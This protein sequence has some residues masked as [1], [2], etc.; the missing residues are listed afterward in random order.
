MGKIYT[1][2][3]WTD[4]LLS[5]SALYNILTNLGATI[6]NNV[7]IAL[8]T[9]VTTPGTSLTAAVMNNI[10]NGIDALDNKLVIDEAVLTALSGQ[11]QNITNNRI[12][13]SVASNNLTVALKGVD[14]NNPS[15]TN[16]VTVRIGNTIRTVTSALSVTL[17]AGTNWFGSGAAELAT[18]EIDYFVYLGY[19]VIDGVTIGV[20]RVPA[21]GLYGDFSATSTNAL[22]AAIS[23][24]THAAAGDEYT[25]IGRFAATLS[26]SAAYQWSV[27]TFT[28]DNLINRPIYETRWLLWQPTYSASGSMTWTSVLTYTASYQIRGDTLY[29]AVS[30]IG[31]T[32]GTADKQL[33]LTV[34]MALLSNSGVAAGTVLQDGAGSYISGVLI[35]ATPLLCFRRYDAANFGLGAVRT[36]N[37][38]SFY[39]V[40]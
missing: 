5:G 38:S 4:E 31:T 27:P 15:S 2:N 6:Y 3:T 8:A 21:A 26:A 34:P 14:G 37:L 40:M 16:P 12:V 7:Q 24:I 1:K 28:N 11:L 9:S 32:G 23:T 19:N 39:R 33:Q 18:K 20:A 30:A 17:N 13:P 10:E 35:P 36:A 22:Y 25:V 29:F